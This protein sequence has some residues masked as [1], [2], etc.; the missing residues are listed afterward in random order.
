MERPIG[1]G[2]LVG[3]VFIALFMMALAYVRIPDVLA[4]GLLMSAMLTSIVI[5]PKAVPRIVHVPLFLLALLWMAMELAPEFAFQ[6]PSPVCVGLLALP[7]VAISVLELGKL[8]KDSADVLPRLAFIIFWGEIAYLLPYLLATPMPKRQILSG[9]GC[10][11]FGCGDQ[12]SGVN[13]PPVYVY[14]LGNHFA[15]SA[16]IVLVLFAAILGRLA[17]ERAI[18]GK[19]EIEEQQ[20]A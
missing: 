3:T 7:A 12:L 19:S 18:G 4:T 14:S 13:D 16:A 2:I 9:I 17:L 15:G 20:E 6:S 10:M 8:V 5:P 1:R 11:D